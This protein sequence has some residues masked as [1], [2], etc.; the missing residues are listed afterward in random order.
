M[1]IMQQLYYRYYITEY[2]FSNL[3]ASESGIRTC[4]LS[5]LVQVQAAYD[6]TPY[7]SS[8]ASFLLDDDVDEAPMRCQ[9]QRPEQ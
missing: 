5:L 1:T 8:Q 9:K 7:P 2:V 6:P 4:V 3:L